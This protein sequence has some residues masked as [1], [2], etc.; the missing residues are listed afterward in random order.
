MSMQQNEYLMYAGIR[1]Y[2]SVSH[3]SAMYAHDL[4]R[5]ND[6][7]RLRTD[8]AVFVQRYRST[9][10]SRRQSLELSRTVQTCGVAGSMIERYYAK[11]S[12]T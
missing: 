10:L 5:V 8:V 1:L 6:R 2:G 11:R 3:P 7:A 12:M 9:D 4:S